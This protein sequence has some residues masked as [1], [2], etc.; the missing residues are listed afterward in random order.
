MPQTHRPDGQPCVDLHD[1]QPHVDLPV[2]PSLS[3]F[4]YTPEDLHDLNVQIFVD[5]HDRYVIC[6]FANAS[7]YN[8]GHNV[9]ILMCR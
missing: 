8:I 4:D 5:R 9:F 2:D 3:D 7:V 6:T 1:R